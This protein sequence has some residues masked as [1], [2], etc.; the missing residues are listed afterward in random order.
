MVVFEKKNEKK[1]FFGKCIISSILIR[2]RIK[3][4]SNNGAQMDISNSDDEK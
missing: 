1:E 3:L 2:K 4:D